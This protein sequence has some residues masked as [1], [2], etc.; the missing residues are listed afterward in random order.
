M[1]LRHVVPEIVGSLKV[2]NPRY[3]G[4]YP[5]RNCQHQYGHCNFVRTDA[6]TV[7]TTPSMLRRERVQKRERVLPILG[8]ALRILRLDQRR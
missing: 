5:K 6:R 2:S 7:S 8:R 4:R 1:E 3:N